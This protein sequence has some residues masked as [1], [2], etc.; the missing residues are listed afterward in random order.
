M[1]LRDG[2]IQD[3]LRP[4]HYVAAISREVEEDRRT[5]IP[6]EVADG[7]TPVAALG[8]YLESRTVDPE[9]REKMLRYAEEMVA[10][11]PLDGAPE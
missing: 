9:R 5:R 4:A 8:L 11:E 6:A 10:E 3:A 7:L 1:Q 2:E